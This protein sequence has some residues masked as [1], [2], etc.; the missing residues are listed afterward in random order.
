MA[1]TQLFSTVANR[2]FL[3]FADADDDLDY[4]K[5][6]DFLDLDDND[7]SKMAQVKKT[8]V[9]L[10][11]AIPGD[12]A[13]RLREIANI[14][15]LVAEFFGGDVVRT[16]AWFHAANP[17]LGNIKPRDMLRLGRY[18]KLYQFVLE[19]REEAGWGHA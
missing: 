6:A 13:Q 3:G 10:E 18:H 16:A 12:L 17:I 11:G 5:V 4:R 8:A 9:R 1:T 7:L 15:N 14:A 19:A 2:D